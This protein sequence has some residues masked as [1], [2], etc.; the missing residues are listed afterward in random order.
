[1]ITEY[2]QF[3]IEESTVESAGI[4]G[5][6]I[7]KSYKGCDEF[8][9]YLELDTTTNKWFTQKTEKRWVKTLNIIEGHTVEDLL[10]LLE[11]QVPRTPMKFV[12]HNGG[13]VRADLLKKR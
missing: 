1:M 12:R 8:V 7:S 13:W 2:K 5:L 4:S 6:R 3:K 10:D 11:K 9:A